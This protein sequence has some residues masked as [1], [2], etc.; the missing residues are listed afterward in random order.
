MANIFFVVTKKNGKSSEFNKYSEKSQV[1][2]N[3]IGKSFEIFRKNSGEI[4]ELKKL[5]KIPE[6]K[7]ISEFK[8][9]SEKIP[10]KF[11]NLIG[12]YKKLPKSS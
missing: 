2:A 8:K 12:I 9:N 11:L 4:P 3:K 10:E 1:T 6:F 7:K 5:M